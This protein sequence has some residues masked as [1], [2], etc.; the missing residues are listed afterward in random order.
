MDNS[1]NMTTTETLLAARPSI[2]ILASIIGFI[3][4]FIGAVLPV[5]QL[6]VAIV[7]LVIGLLTIEAKLKD[8]KYKKNKS[9]KKYEDE[10]V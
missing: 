1:L 7:G 3:T 2:G 9:S 8:R 4:P 5:V 10:T 6:L